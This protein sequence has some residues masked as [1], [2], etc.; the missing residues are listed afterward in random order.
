MRLPLKASDGNKGN[1]SSERF[2]RHFSFHISK[3]SRITLLPDQMEMATSEKPKGSK[4]LPALQ[5][6]EVQCVVCVFHVYH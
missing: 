2:V 1:V 6:L 5:T 4:L 3:E